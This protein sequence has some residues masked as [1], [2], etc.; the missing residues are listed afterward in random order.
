MLIGGGD[1]CEHH[2]WGLGDQGLVANGPRFMICED[3]SSE[4][5]HIIAMNNASTSLKI[6][7]WNPKKQAWED[8]FYPLV[9]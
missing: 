9:N 3:L 2:P 8:P 6:L 4:Q 1:P 7:T 5:P